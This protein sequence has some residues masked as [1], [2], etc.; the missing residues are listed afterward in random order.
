MS[1]GK[2]FFIALVGVMLLITGCVNQLGVRTY[3]DS[4]LGI[5]FDYPAAWELEIRS[6][7]DKEG[8]ESITFEF[9]EDDFQAAIAG[10]RIGQPKDMDQKTAV[11]SLRDEFASRQALIPPEHFLLLQPPTTAPQALYDVAVGSYVVTTSIPV[12]SVIEKQ[13]I[14]LPVDFRITFKLVHTSDRTIFFEIIAQGGA[15]VAP[16]YDLIVD[17]FDLISD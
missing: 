10:V 6:E 5:T 3:T 16:G 12:D 2:Y 11:E 9:S 7:K 17:S 14:S 15:V 1:Q 8:V 13:A 4:V